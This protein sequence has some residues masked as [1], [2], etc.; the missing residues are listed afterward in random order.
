VLGAYNFDVPRRSNARGF[1]LIELLVVIAVI[2]ILA[3]LLLPALSHVKE[4][5]H[6]IQCKNNLRQWAIALQ[7]YLGDNQVYPG[8]AVMLHLEKYVGEKYPVPRFGYYSGGRGVAVQKPINSVYHCPSYDRLPGWYTSMAAGWGPYGYNM[9]GVGTVSFGVTTIVSGLGLAGRTGTYNSGM[10]RNDFPPIHE[11]A[12]VNPANMIAL[13]DARLSWLT[14]ESWGTGPAHKPII[15]GHIYLYHL[16]ISA[17]RQAD[18]IGLSEGVYQRRHRAQ[19]NTLFCDGHIETL[20]IKNLF[21]SRPE[22]M[23]RWNNDAQPHREF[24]GPE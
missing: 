10:L 23:A 20:K 14:G 15:T 9:G 12:V 17:T 3:A 21:S 6:T 18:N 1:T 5:A 19:F 24:A 2:A 22:I 16:P 4:Q 7:L 11:N 13:A 8:P